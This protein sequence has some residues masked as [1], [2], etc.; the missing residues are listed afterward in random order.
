ML[1]RNEFRDEQHE[2]EADDGEHH[3]HPGRDGRERTR[4]CGEQ[5]GGRTVASVTG[6]GRPSRPN[7]FDQL[8]CRPPERRS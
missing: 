8:A 6:R 1:D 7:G 5:G 2:R 4:L 3:R